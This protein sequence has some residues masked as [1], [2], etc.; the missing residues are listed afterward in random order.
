[1]G[2]DAEEDSLVYTI[3]T[4]P[5]HGTVTLDPTDSSRYTYSPD[6]DY[7]GDDSFSY[8]VFD[9]EYDSAVDGVIYIEVLSVNDEAG[10]LR[11][12]PRCR[13]DQRAR[14]PPGRPY[15]RPDGR[16]RR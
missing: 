5:A 6:T 13:R 15:R 7:N 11:R 16:H 4:P 3:V 12:Q 2:T 1:M 10:R 8:S 9:G 14:R